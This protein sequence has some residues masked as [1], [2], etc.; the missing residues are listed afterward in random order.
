MIECVLNYTLPYSRK[1]EVKFGNEHWYKHVGKLIKTNHEGKVTIL[2]NQ[3][4]QSD[5]T[6][7][8]NKPDIMIHV[9]KEGSYLP[10]DIAISGER[11][12]IKKE[13]KR[14]Y[15]I[16]AKLY[17]LERRFVAGV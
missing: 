12:M 5:R 16:A 15:R 4:V 2:W 8:N 14:N 6:I 9:N 7:A 11:N 10:V 13:A 17:T 1:I 3:Q